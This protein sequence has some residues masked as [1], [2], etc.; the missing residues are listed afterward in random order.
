MNEVNRRKTDADRSR[1]T[2]GS[3]CFRRRHHEIVAGNRDTSVFL[4]DDDAPFGFIGTFHSDAV[5]PGVGVLKDHVILK[6]DVIQLYHTVGDSGLT[7]SAGLENLNSGGTTAHGVVPALNAVAANDQ[8]AAA[9]T[10]VGTVAYASD[11]LVGHIS[12]GAGGILDGTVE[13]WKIH[14][15]FTG[16]FDAFKVRG[17]LAGGSSTVAGVTATAWNG[18]VS[19][20]AKFDMFTLAAAFEASNLT[21]GASNVTQWGGSVTGSAAVTDQVTI[22]AGFRW[23]DSDTSTA[24]SESYQAALRLIAALTETL[25]LTGE[26]GYYSVGSAIPAVRAD[27]AFYGS[28]ELA[29]TPGGQFTSSIKGEMN[30]LGGYKATF[31][32]SKKFD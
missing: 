32:A 29:W 19:A 26:V 20:E 13:D 12:V 30:S 3:L 28:A 6:G 25:K 15:G 4:E 2:Q 31:K 21:R 5:D 14:A 16:T 22:E 27:G 11:A 23:Y 1:F 17:A 8:A 24:N 7:V 9:G 10:L 18:L